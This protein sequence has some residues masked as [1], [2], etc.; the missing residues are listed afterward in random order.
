MVRRC[1]GTAHRP[2]E[3]RSRCAQSLIPSVVTLRPAAAAAV[4]VEHEESARARRPLG[5]LSAT[6]D[7]RSDSACSVRRTPQHY[8]LAGRFIRSHSLLGTLLVNAIAL[9]VMG[10]WSSLCAAQRRPL[11]ITKIIGSSRPFSTL[12]LETMALFNSGGTKAANSYAISSTML[13]LS[14]LYGDLKLE[15]PSLITNA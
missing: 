15:R 9:F 11:S 10:R 6:F 12:A 7:S 14:V 13:G 5:Y 1:T 3:R 4:P 8:L 2:P